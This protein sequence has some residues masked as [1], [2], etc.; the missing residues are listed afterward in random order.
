MNNKSQSLELFSQF[1]SLI[2]KKGVRQTISILKENLSDSE[3]N[4]R[5]F[6]AYI[7]NVVCTEFNI[8]KDELFY[9]KSRKGGR[10]A[11]ALSVFC[12]LMKT[13]ADMSQKDIADFLDKDPV[14]V[15]RYIKTFNSLSTKTKVE[16]EL[17]RKAE[18]IKLEIDKYEN[19]G[20]ED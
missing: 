18:N 2:E 3:D 20:E 12:A 13:E 4:K 7:T 8:T 14:L 19:Y 9:G 15:H 1:L 11:N 5:M 6:H 17:L 16:K 10:R